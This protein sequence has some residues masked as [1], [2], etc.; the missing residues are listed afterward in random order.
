MRLRRSKVPSKSAA[1]GLANGIAKPQAAAGSAKEAKND[2]LSLLAFGSAGCGA[3]DGA[4]PA[5]ARR[6]RPTGTHGPGT[7]AR[8]GPRSS[9][10]RQRAEPQ[11]GQPHREEP[12]G[13]LERRGEE[14]E[15][16]QVV[17]PAWQR[18]LRRPGH[19]RG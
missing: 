4:G 1:C 13:R 6:L 19:R 2:F 17:G 12:A 7:A 5:P 10:V 3:V 15:E 18:V 11:H 14:G 8:P 9:D 16:Y